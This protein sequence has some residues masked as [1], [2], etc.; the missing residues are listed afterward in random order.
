MNSNTV[1]RMSTIVT[2]ATFSTDEKKR[3]NLRMEWAAEKPKCAI[4][5]T[6]PSTADEYFFDQTSMLVRNSAIRHGYGSVSILNL[7]SSM[8][9]G[10]PKSDKVNTAMILR[11]CSAADVVILAYGRSN[12]F[13]ET[14]NEI[15]KLLKSYKD[16]LYTIEDKKGNLFSHPLSPM[17]REWKIVRVPDDYLDE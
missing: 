14:K 16:K 9:G 2:T 13:V 17:A 12:S 10:V 15:F 1:E 5:M 4:I 6:Y 7:F 8:E 3:Y 11:E